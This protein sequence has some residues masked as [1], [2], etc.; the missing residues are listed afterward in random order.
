MPCY[1][2]DILKFSG[3]LKGQV[4]LIFSIFSKYL[5]FKIY[6]TYCMS[7]QTEDHDIG[8]QWN[9]LNILY[10]NKNFSSDISLKLEPKR[11]PQKK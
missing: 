6:Q 10:A 3:Q 7:V 4:I 5:K 9:C 11:E 1:Q 8:S 2:I